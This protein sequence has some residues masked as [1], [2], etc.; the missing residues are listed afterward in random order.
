[1]DN[2]D[3]KNAEEEKI[4]KE[5][6]QVEIMIGQILRIGVII[7]AVIMLIGF[8]AYGIQGSTGLPSHGAVTI[9]AIATGLLSFK[10]GSVMMLGLFCLI[11]TPVLRVVVSIYAFYVE[12]DSLYV[13][14]TSAVLVILLF[15]LFIGHS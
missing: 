9:T 1:M 11:L 7:S 8:I 13:W 12:K 3:T 2:K 15:A 5:M 14:I 6:A 4:S 10:S